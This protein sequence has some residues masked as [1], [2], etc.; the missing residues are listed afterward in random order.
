MVIGAYGQ[1]IGAD[2]NGVFYPSWAD[3]CSNEWTSMGNTWTSWCSSEGFD[4]SDNYSGI[5]V[6]GTIFIILITVLPCL[7]IIACVIG[8]C[9][10][11]D[12][13]DRQRRGGNMVQQSKYKVAYG[14]RILHTFTLILPNDI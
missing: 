7:C 3:W 4:Y 8:C 14:D 1:V 5:I 9:I 11:C 13:H 6:G 2:S 12:R 10:C